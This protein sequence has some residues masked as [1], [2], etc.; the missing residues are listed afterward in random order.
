MDNHQT[1][2]DRLAT[3]IQN[4]FSKWHQGVLSHKKLSIIEAGKFSRSEKAQEIARDFVSKIE[5][6][7]EGQESAFSPGGITQPPSEFADSPVPSPEP[8]ALKPGEVPVSGQSRTS[9][10]KPVIIPRASFAITTN[11]RV[12]EAFQAAINGKGAA[13][14]KVVVT[15]VDFPEEIGL[16]FDVETQ[17]LSGVPL[18]AGEYLLKLK[19]HYDYDDRS[20]GPQLDGE[21]A[22]VVNHD[23]WSLWTHKP[24]DPNDEYPKR[25]EDCDSL[26]GS[27]GLRML[28]ASKRGRSHAH[29]GSFRDDDFRLLNDEASGWRLLAVADGAGSAKKSR[30]GSEIAVNIAAGNVMAG[31]A[32]DAGK[33][34]IA[35]INQF[36][37]DATVGK[38]INEKL[39]YL[40]GRAA[41]DAV[42]A[43]LSESQAKE[44]PY[45]D[46][47]TTLLIAIHR[48]VTAGH[49]VG[50]YWVGDGGIGI[51]RE[52]QEVKVL[53]RADSGEF[54][55]QTRFLDQSMVQPGEIV[56]RIRF[57]IVPDFTAIVAMTD[58]ITDPWFETDSNL[59]NLDKWRRLWSEIAP[60]LLNTESPEKSLLEWLDFKITGNHD[61]RTIAVLCAQTLSAVDVDAPANKVDSEKTETANAEASA[62]VGDY[63][64]VE[65]TD[66]D[67]ATNPQESQP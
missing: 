35:L 9:A 5:T 29:V 65:Q 38:S 30:K 11:A 20:D 39:Y 7:L 46:Y 16:V 58:G 52:G 48:Q 61:D 56:S 15:S 43:I 59:E 37:Q 18:Q 3:L 27:D 44:Y 67:K 51:Y 60:P 17:S 22:L 19:Y 8:S 53:G 21:V 64:A 36:G 26:P 49:F 28:A 57:A 45:K 47:S 10:A 32:G 14:T 62:D 13:G 24:S 34:L 33:E 54:A 63:Q 4:L 12:N 6:L 50:A 25:D 42:N 23:P 66:G 41:M 2:E 55:G 1:D 31:L 40:F